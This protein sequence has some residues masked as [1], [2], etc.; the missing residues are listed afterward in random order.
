MKYDVTK[1]QGI[2]KEC[3][4]CG[5]DNKSGLQAKFYELENKELMAI[6]TPNDEHQSYPGRLHGGV[7]AAIL[8]ETIGRAVMIEEPDAW[9]VTVELNLKYKKPTPLNKPL[10]VRA[11][12]T[13]NTRLLFEGT[14]EILLDNGDVAVQA[15]GKYV[16]MTLN[17]ISDK[18]EIAGELLLDDLS[19][20]PESI[21]I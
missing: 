10:R 7:A 1:K 16:K 20:G 13:R 2:S 14:G 19:D 9:G 4:V 6:F 11:R 5:I 18:S 3:F 15:Y 12:L 21:E 17:K 8:D